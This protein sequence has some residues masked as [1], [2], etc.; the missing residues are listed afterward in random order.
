MN[1]SR[2]RRISLGVTVLAIAMLS[3][4]CDEGSSSSANT[5]IVADAG[6]DIGADATDDSSQLDAET[7]AVEIDR[8]NDTW[9][10]ATHENGIDPDYATVFPDD[11][12]LRLDITI[13]AEDWATM[14][15][16]LDEN[17]DGG[18]GPGGADL[19]FTPVVTEASIA[20]N[21]AVWNHVGIRFKGNSSLFN[22]Y[23]EGEKYPMKLDFDEW[24]DLYPAVDDQRFFGFK[25]LNLG[26]NYKD[27]SFMRDKVTN[28]LFRDFGV[29]AA[30]A[31]FAEVYLDIGDGLEFVGVYALVEEV[32]DT[33]YEEQFESDEGNL[34][35]PDGDGATFAHGE[36]NTEEM[37]LK[38]NE[39][40]ADYSDVEALYAVLHD[41]QRTSD[42]EAWTTALEG[43][44][45]V[46]QFLRYLAAN[47]VMQNWDTYGV[48]THNFFLYNDGGALV[49]I[50]WDNNE[51]LSDNRR[52]LS[53]TV[54]EVGDDWPIIRYIL[55]V[56]SYN[57][58]YI[59]L[60]QEFVANHFNEA[61]M[62]ET[63]DAYEAL[64]SDIA[65]SEDPDFT[66][67]VEQLR[68]H[69]ADRE[70]A[71]DAL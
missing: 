3:A 47:Q 28:D 24:E 57:A 71:V 6:S 66:S 59:E 19:D 14:Q 52:T 4:G 15:A 33:V 32:D 26:S 29:P 7:D 63:Y 50:P 64:I 36:F 49:W 65:L 34:Y 17:L 8:E 48:M 18:G 38:T 16:D 39:D 25:Q 51:A 54:D 2:L 58:R 23:Q 55:D 31:A 53:L 42:E 35:K 68:Q 30:H 56:D 67:A 20:F 69:A 22:A 11:E 27:S 41:D 45:N 60:M 40:E 13:S 43:V 61:Q 62:V 46:E 70:A 44:F 10:T 9:T 1:I 21:G 37:D 5:D 12:V